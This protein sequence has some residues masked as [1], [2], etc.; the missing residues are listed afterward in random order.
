MKEITYGLL[1]IFFVLEIF[2]FLFVYLFGAQGMQ[3]L[4][5]LRRENSKL[6][7]EL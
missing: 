5:Q 2:A 6:E 7:G 3:V 4:L 1:R